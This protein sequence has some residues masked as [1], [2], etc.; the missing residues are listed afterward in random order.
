MGSLARYQNARCTI[1]FIQQEPNA[2]N[3]NR[4]FAVD[5]ILTPSLINMEFLH[6]HNLAGYS[7][8]FC[9]HSRICGIQSYTRMVQAFIKH[10]EEHHD[11]NNS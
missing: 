4:P 9:F 8:A 1:S 5:Y 11:T 6:M 2:K 3:G 10:S 7:G